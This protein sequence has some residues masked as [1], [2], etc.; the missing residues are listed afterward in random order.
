MNNL[1]NVEIVERPINISVLRKNT[2]YHDQIIN[3]LLN[4]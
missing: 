3:A 1:E 4:S 2:K